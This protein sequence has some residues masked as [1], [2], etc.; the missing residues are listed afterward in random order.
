MSI[1]AGRPEPDAQVLR[2]LTPLPGYA[3]AYPSAPPLFQYTGKHPLHLTRPEGSKTLIHLQNTLSD[4][5]T[6]AADFHAGTS[7]GGIPFL[8][9]AIKLFPG[10]AMLVRPMDQGGD[11]YMDQ[12]AVSVPARTPGRSNGTWS[13]Y[14]LPSEPLPEAEG[15]WTPAPSSPYK[16]TPSYVQD[17]AVV[18]SEESLASL[19]RRVLLGMDAYFQQQT[20]PEC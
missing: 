1:P 2:G 11:P 3:L 16:G 13:S 6:R 12:I 19:S 9:G 8:D 17:G 20:P 18:M 10:D 15:V 7:R 5:K 14:Q 4:A